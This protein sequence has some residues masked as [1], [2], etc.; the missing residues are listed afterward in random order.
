MIAREREVR[1]SMVEAGHP[2]DSIMTFQAVQTKSSDMRLH[3]FWRCVFV[4]IKAGQEVR[5]ESCWRMTV[6]ALE[7]RL[8]VIERVAR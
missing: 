4:T 7:R 3:E 2:V 8:V 1:F 6:P 5:I